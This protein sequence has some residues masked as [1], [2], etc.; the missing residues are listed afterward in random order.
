ME[1]QPD[2]TLTSARLLAIVNIIILSV[3]WVMIAKPTF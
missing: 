3:V 1:R 2:K